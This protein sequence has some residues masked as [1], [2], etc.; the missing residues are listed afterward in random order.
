LPLAKSQ[1]RV[2]EPEIVFGGHQDTDIFFAHDGKF[3]YE[4]PIEM[5]TVEVDQGLL[6]AGVEGWK[7]GPFEKAF[8][9][10]AQ[11]TSGLEAEDLEQV[12]KIVAEHVANRSE[13]FEAFGMKFPM[14]QVTLWG[15]VVLLGVQLYFFLCLKQLSGKLGPEDPGWD[16]PWISMDQSFLAQA[17]FFTTVI[18]LP[19]IARILLG[20]RG[21]LQLTAG[22]RADSWHAAVKFKDWQWAVRLGIAAY[23]LAG[24]GALTLGIAS[25]TFRPRLRPKMEQHG[26]V[27]LF[28]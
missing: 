22:Y 25:W 19:V 7:R 10:L 2:I 21:S 24:I 1:P 8:A 11:Q 12:E 9:A 4:L 3:Q 26:P 17:I 27:Q 5:V 6:S 14:E 23:L 28:E 18:V 16:I 15:T 20:G 13:E